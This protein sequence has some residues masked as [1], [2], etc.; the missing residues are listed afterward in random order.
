MMLTLPEWVQNRLKERVKV[1]YRSITVVAKNKVK[2][3]S[4]S[5]G[6]KAWKKPTWYHYEYFFMNYSPKWAQ[7]FTI[8]THDT[9]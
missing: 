3:K 6:M 7:I 4:I 2:V 5:G 1:S 9:F 8:L